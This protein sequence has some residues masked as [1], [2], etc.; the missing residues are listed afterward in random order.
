[1]QHDSQAAP[2]GPQIPHSHVFAC[3]APL[4]H[5]ALHSHCIHQ[6]S[7]LPYPPSVKGHTWLEHFEKCTVNKHTVNSMVTASTFDESTI[8]ELTINKSTFNKPTVEKNHLLFVDRHSSH[9][10]VG[11]FQFAGDHSV[12]LV[13][14]PPLFEVFGFWNL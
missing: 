14:F 5:A 3:H 8:N 9:Y 6:P 4:I 12:G 7:F 2:P 13:C 10:F 11:I 1:M